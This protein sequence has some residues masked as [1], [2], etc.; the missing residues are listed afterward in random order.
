M[1][2]K[3]GACKLILYKTSRLVLVPYNITYY[4]LLNNFYFYKFDYVISLITIFL[5]TTKQL[6]LFIHLR[7]YYYFITFFLYINHFFLLLFVL[8]SIFD[9]CITL[10][11]SIGI[12]QFLFFKHLYFYCTVVLRIT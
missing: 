7:L 10:F 8:T 3:L 5:Y 6:L 2:Q 9:G 4:I 12:L 1:P 11:Y